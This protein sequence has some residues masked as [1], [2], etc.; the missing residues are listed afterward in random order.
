[1]TDADK[2]TP[3]D[4]AKLYYSY[5]EDTD[6][7][8]VADQLDDEHGMGW[9]AYLYWPRMIARA[10]QAKA[11]GW[12]NTTPRSLA[13]SIHDNLN[14]GGSWAA[15]ARM[16]ELLA[17][18][19]LIRVLQGSVENPSTK[20]D[21]LLV[22]Y[23]KWQSLSAKERQRLSRERRRVEEGQEPHWTVRHWSDFAFRPLVADCDIEAASCDVVTGNRDTHP[24]KR[25]AVTTLDETRQDEKEGARDRA[26]PPSV[27]ETLDLVRD[28]PGLSR[29]QL[30]SHVRKAMA[31]YPSL[32]DHAVCE[33]ITAFETRLPEGR[34]VH[35]AKAWQSIR[36]CF[37]VARKR[38][39]EGHAAAATASGGAAPVA[40]LE[41]FRALRSGAVT[42]T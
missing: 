28:L 19:D 10:K 20:I 37:D 35:S 30:E 21:V 26:L 24:V 18:R 22:E 34:P 12:F 2:I 33:A 6:L 7:A 38:L 41:E 15:R 40:L 32:P 31:Q 13:V 16:W 36:N 3:D 14:S 8:M 29:W 42:S 23:E 25:D 1:V 9:L 5:H 17:E 11:L 27:Q 39:D 4:Y